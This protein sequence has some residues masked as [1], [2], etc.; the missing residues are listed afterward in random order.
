[1]NKICIKCSIPKI[2]D[3]FGKL[4]KNK[5]GLNNICKICKRLYDNEHH[6]N[7]NFD[8]KNDKYQ[9]QVI[10]LKTIKKFVYDYLSKKECIICSEKR[11]PALDFHH[12]NDKNFNVSDGIKNGYSLDKIK[13]EIEKCNILCANCHRVETAEAFN[14]YTF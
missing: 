2:I 1:M 7:R 8:K 11:I 13:K 9:K 14:W 4:S 6:K 5:D 3:D 12:L 10:R